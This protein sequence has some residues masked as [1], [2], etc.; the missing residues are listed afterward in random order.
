[1][2]SREDEADSLH[3]LLPCCVL[4][5]GVWHLEGRP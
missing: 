5:M 1:V 3:G 4:G 2:A